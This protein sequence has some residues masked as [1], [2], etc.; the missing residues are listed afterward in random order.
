MYLCMDGISLLFDF[1]VWEIDF[2]DGLEET[3]L[4]SRRG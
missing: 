4:R 2:Q 3:I 1:L